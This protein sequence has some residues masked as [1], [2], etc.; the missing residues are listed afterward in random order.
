M[1]GTSIKFIYATSHPSANNEASSWVG[2]GGELPRKRFM[3]SSF[4]ETSAFLQIRGAQRSLLS[5]S[6]VFQL[7]PV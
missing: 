2:A 3:A 1:E 4:S 6:A 7:S 5:T